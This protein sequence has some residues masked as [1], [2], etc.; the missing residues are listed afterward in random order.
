VF[1]LKKAGMRSIIHNSQSDWVD[2]GQADREDPFCKR[3]IW[4]LI[5]TGQLPAYRPL[6]KKILI[7]RSDLNKLIE[8]KRV[9]A[10]LDKIV[11]EVVAEVT[12]NGK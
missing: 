5:S 12:G 8:A 11:D 7:K 10:D 9:G 2:L 1:L 6:K 3:T 4:K